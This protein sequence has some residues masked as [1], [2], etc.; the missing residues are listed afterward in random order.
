[1]TSYLRDPSARATFEKMGWWESANRVRYVVMVRGIPFRIKRTAQSPGKAL[2]D[3]A[4]VD[5][6]LAVLGLEMAHRCQ[7]P[8]A[9]LGM[10]NRSGLRTFTADMQR[11]C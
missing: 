6:E 9:I 10:T 1:L 8:F 4:S 3:E 11:S 7:G 5:S 2:E